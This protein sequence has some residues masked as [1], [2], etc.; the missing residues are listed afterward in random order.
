MFE[1]KKP[2]RECACSCPRIHD[3]PSCSATA[4]APSCLINQH[5]M[6]MRNEMSRVEVAWLRRALMAFTKP[7]NCDETACYRHA[8][9]LSRSIGTLL[10]DDLSPCC[11]RLPVLPHPKFIISLHFRRSHPSISSNPDLIHW[12]K[13]AGLQQVLALPTISTAQPRECS[14]VLWRQMTS[15]DPG[16]GL[17]SSLPY[18]ISPHPPLPP[19]PPRFLLPTF[20]VPCSGIVGTRQDT[21]EK[22]GSALRYQQYQVPMKIRGL[23]PARPPGGL[24]AGC[25][26]SV[27]LLTPD[28]GSEGLSVQCRLAGRAVTALE[29]RSGN[30]HTCDH[31]RGQPDTTGGSP[32]DHRV[33]R[34]QL[35]SPGIIPAA[36]EAL[37]GH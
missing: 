1:L 36:P 4:S 37:P 9:T 5:S 29:A 3:D 28:E 13:L 26:A 10:H 6:Q 14:H 22:N 20:H 19:S 27:L 23:A 15:R 35:K 31:C 30:S 8:Q 2:I 24:R 34:G 21:I 7:I 16:P 33:I 25:G 11:L 12:S 18:F 17:T 32:S